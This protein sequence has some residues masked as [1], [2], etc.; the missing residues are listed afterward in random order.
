MVT[1]SGI[2]PSLVL[3]TVET[4]PFPLTQEAFLL[5]CFHTYIPALTLL[6]EKRERKGTRHCQIRQKMGEVFF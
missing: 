4:P 5:S 3:Y 1:I 2:I 6:T